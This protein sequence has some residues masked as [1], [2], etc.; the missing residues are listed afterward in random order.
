MI[1]RREISSRVFGGNIM[2]VI[3]STE[4]KGGTET[5]PFSKTVPQCHWL[6]YAPESVRKSWS[7]FFGLRAQFAWREWAQVNV[8]SKSPGD[9]REKVSATS[10]WTDLKRAFQQIREHMREIL[11]ARKQNPFL[12]Y[13]CCIFN[14]VSC[15]WGPVTANGMRK[16][17]HVQFKIIYID[18]TW[19]FF[20]QTSLF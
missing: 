9:R 20:F 3:Y 14:L 6:P 11:L 17:L 5:V 2:F 12:G 10:T 7:S 18:V 8:K 15:L 16:V 19:Y 4:K 1:S 13:F